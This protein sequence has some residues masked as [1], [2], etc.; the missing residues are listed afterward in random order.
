[1]K[2]LIAILM[3]LV[4]ALT[5][6]CTFAAAED[7]SVP[8][9][10]PE[11][12]AYESAWIS[13]DGQT[14]VWIGRQDDGFQIEA[15]Q[16]T[17]ENAFTSWQYL[18]NFDA[19]TKSIKDAQGIKGDYK[20]TEEGKDELIEGSSAD[21][22][23]ASFTLGEDG[24]LT[25]KDE[26]AGKETVLEKIGNF[27]GSY[28]YTRGVLSFVWDTHENHYDIMVTWL[29]EENEKSTKVWD[30]ELVGEYDAKT[31]TVNFKGLKQL[32][33]YKEDGEIDTSAKVEEGELE[34]SFTFNKD[35][36][37]VWKSSDGSGDGIVFENDLIPLWGCIIG[38]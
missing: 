36:G 18:S 8:P 1:M 24:K 25:W 4:L 5:L 11:M 34:G 16:T 37:L 30:Y 33:T 23:K 15:V 32:L 2:K 10:T 12:K 7:D 38:V 26:Q 20:V 9:S 19:E 14:L 17:G 29:E 22:V 28:T 35:G 3:A 6:G 27:I 31:E 13:E 21:D